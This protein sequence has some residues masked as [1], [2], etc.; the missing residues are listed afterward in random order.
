MI[1]DV[2]AKQRAG[3]LCVQDA[4]EGESSDDTNASQGHGDLA[5]GNTEEEHF[6]LTLSMCPH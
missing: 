4:A 2:R 6:S 1:P 5:G 3:N